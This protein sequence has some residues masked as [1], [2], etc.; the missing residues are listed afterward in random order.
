MGIC[1]GE[2]QLHA[3]TDSSLYEVQNVQDSWRP[4]SQGGGMP[5]SPPHTLPAVA[6]VR[7]PKV[8]TPADFCAKV[9]FC[10]NAD[11]PDGLLSPAGSRLLRR[12]R[13]R[14]VQATRPGQGDA[15]GV[16][17]GEGGTGVSW[18]ARTFG[19]ATTS[20]SPSS[21]LRDTNM[22]KDN[23]LPSALSSRNKRRY[24]QPDWGPTSA[25]FFSEPE[26]PSV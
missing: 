23:A 2:A 15:S 12:G 16:R 4:G 10:S 6:P 13:R 18:D 5:G 14:P 20:L 26:G 8:L 9:A 19:P 21:L 25:I 1:V 7:H 24:G 22:A 17:P 11:T 3:L